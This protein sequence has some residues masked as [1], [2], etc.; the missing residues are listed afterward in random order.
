MNFLAHLLCGC[1]EA[2][3]ALQ[4][5]LDISSFGVVRCL[6]GQF[7]A[8]GVQ[9]TI[10][11]VVN[12][13]QSSYY[14]LLTALEDIRNLSFFSLERPAN[15]RTAVLELT[16][17]VGGLGQVV[18]RNNRHSCLLCS[19]LQCLC[20]AVVNDELLSVVIDDRVGL[21]RRG[22][23]ACEDSQLHFRSRFPDFHN[24]VGL[25]AHAL[26]NGEACA[27]LAGKGGFVDI[28]RQ[29]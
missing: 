3:C 19:G 11:A 2:L 21:A 7:C 29:V 20:V 4:L 24:L 27:T 17:F 25:L 15:D 9:R 1:L 14:E 10:F 6:V 28:L 13:R 26:S 16:D 18:L 5:L 23:L 22:Y 12:L 8:N